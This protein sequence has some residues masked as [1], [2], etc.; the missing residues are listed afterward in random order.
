ML[1]RIHRHPNRVHNRVAVVVS[2]KIAKK[3][4]V[5]NRI[6]RRIYEAL[7]TEWAEIGAPYDIVFIITN[8]EVGPLEFEELRREVTTLLKRGHLT[9]LNSAG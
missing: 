9:H 8:P 3:A 1:L 4:T 2:K 6:R 7:R 5:R